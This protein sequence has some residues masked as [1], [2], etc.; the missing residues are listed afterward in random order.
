MTLPTNIILPLRNEA[1]LS[2]DPKR[3]Q[4][5]QRELIFKLQEMYADI[6]QNV[7]GDIKEFDSTVSGTTSAGV[8]IYDSQTGW[9][10]RQ[11]LMVDVWFDVEW[12]AHTG[13]GDLFLQLPYKV[14]NTR[15]FGETNKPFVGVLQ[16]SSVTFAV[17]TAATINA[18][19]DTF[20]GE[21]WE[22]G[23]AVATANIAL[24]GTGQIIGHV[25][26][27]GTEFEM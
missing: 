25:R 2:N 23:T 22:Y 7:N 14:F 5:Y 27:V 20:R 11:G 26:Y 24:A 9:Y 12:T 21:I 15:A 17:G 13:T 8:G 16:T 3:N 6:V 18:I 10:L 19:P 4:Q 1:I